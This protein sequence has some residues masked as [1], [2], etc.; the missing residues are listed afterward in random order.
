V[1]ARKDVGSRVFYPGMAGKA[2]YR[3]WRSLPRLAQ[4]SQIPPTYSYRVRML[5]SWVLD[6]GFENGPLVL[7]FVRMSVTR[8]M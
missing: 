4:K 1:Q 2:G 5:R 3:R 8:L 6:D 7:R